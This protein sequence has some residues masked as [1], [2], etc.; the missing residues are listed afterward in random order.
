MINSVGV[1]LSLS[2]KNCNQSCQNCEGPLHALFPP[3]HFS[4]PLS[5][6][7]SFTPPPFRMTVRWAVRTWTTL[8]PH[9]SQLSSPQCLSRAHRMERGSATRQPPLKKKMVSGCKPPQHSPLLS[10]H[11]T[12]PCDFFFSFLSLFTS[13]RLQIGVMQETACLVLSG[14]IHINPVLQRVGHHHSP[15]PLVT[16]LPQSLEK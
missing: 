11:H 12:P 6:C 9:G 10:Q 8:S 15:N 16:P 3:V 13:G 2:S 5:R 7:L 4:F 14:L 1:N